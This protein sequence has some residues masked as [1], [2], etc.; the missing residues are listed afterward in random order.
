M[1]SNGDAVAVLG[2]GN[3]GSGI[4]QSLAMA[5]YRVVVRDL[6]E[7]EVER[8]RG[9]IEENL[10]RSIQRGRLTP[11]KKA[12]I[13]SMVEFTTDLKKSVEGADLVIEAVFEELD[14]KLALLDELSKL[15]K[16]DAV[17]VT[18]TSSLSVG[19]LF[20]KFPHPERTAGLH[21]FYPASVNK[22]IEI[23]P[24]P[25]TSKE[26]VEAL[27][28]LTYTLK[29]IPIR[30]KD[31]AGFC[32]NRFF[33]PFLNESCR[34]VEEG[35]A[36]MPTVEAASS[37][38]LGTKAG[39]FSL[40]NAIGIPIAF[41]SVTSLSQTFGRF[42]APADLLK[43]QFEKGAKWTIDGEIDLG[44]L[45][46]VKARL[47]G[48]IIGIATRLV[49][50][51]VATAEDTDRSAVIGLAWDQG[52]FSI[53]NSIGSASSLEQVEAIHQK[54]G[55][56][57]PITERLSELGIAGEQWPLSTVRI[58][59]DGPLAWI[60]LDRPES[61][62]AIN[63]NVLKD[64]EGAIKAVAEDPDAKV[65]LISSTSNVFAAGADIE[66]MVG[67]TTGEAQEFLSMGH[68]V[69]RRIETLEKP[70]IAVVEG[71]ALGGGLELALSADFIIASE[72]AMLGLPEV[73]LGIIPGF[74]GTQR[75]PRLVGKA[76]GKMLV[77]GG[78]QVKATEAYQM[79]FVSRLCPASS[80]KS[81]ARALAMTVASRAP[82]AVRLAKESIER[83]LDGSLGAGLALERQLATYT[84]TTEDLREGM[85]AFL[86]RRP[87]AY[88]GK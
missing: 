52:P 18:N 57:F 62:N 72:T 85:K 65:V 42:Y 54:W 47:A 27:M 39:P 69:M 63:L 58:E 81:E 7:K 82:I 29:K 83:G 37:E 74:G 77:M 64:I 21:F 4:A 2:A 84:F 20:E 17:V 41:H 80:L 28:G 36:N 40:M 87:P 5:G 88:K 31:S 8:G 3:M 14:V 79:G 50:E 34:I 1:V 32:V 56:D 75:L 19:R 67:K 59:K 76:T 38:L 24:G 25:T 12:R 6:T 33:V 44:G 11:E 66:E 49:E 61:M 43:A 51:G 86:E 45:Q 15:V 26:T 60:L 55:N 30:A 73:S 10:S 13:L 70:V 68:R 9:I 53:L 78:I 71:Y 35:V 16:D 22:L 48:V 23:I 46:A